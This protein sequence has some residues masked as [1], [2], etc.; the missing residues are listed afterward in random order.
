MAA[1]HWEAMAIEINSSGPEGICLFGVTVD[2]SCSWY[3]FMPWWFCGSKCI[4]HPMSPWQNARTHS[5]K[6]L[7]VRASSNHHIA[8]HT[9]WLVRGNQSKLQNDTATSVAQLGE[10]TYMT[11]F[12]MLVWSDIS[13]THL[14]F[15]ILNNRFVSNYYYTFSTFRWSILSSSSSLLHHFFLLFYYTTF[16]HGLT[17]SLYRFCQE[18]RICIS[19]H[20][21][22]RF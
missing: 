11:G 3:S 4:H 19:R 5:N 18:V 14:Q 15:R 22:L 13:H 10:T 17:S 6:R 7:N 1:W 9:F 2:L 20:W 16:Q 12:H 21:T 8:Q